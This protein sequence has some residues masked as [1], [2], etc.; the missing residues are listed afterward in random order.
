MKILL[1][2]HQFYPHHYTGTE[3]I[4][5]TTAKYLQKLGH[6]C[7][8]FTYSFHPPS[9]SP[10]WQHIVWWREMYDGLEVINFHWPQAM[11]EFSAIVYHASLKA[12]CDHVIEMVKPDILHVMHPMRSGTICW[13]AQERNIPY[14][15][16]LTDF[17]LICSRGGMLTPAKNLCNGG[18]NGSKCRQICFD[19]PS[20]YYTQRYKEACWLLEHARK[21]MTPSRCLEYLFRQNFAN[22]RSIPVP[23]GI[24]RSFLG[25]NDKKYTS[26]INGKIVYIYCGSLQYIK[27]IQVL[28]AAIQKVR[29]RNIEFRIYGDGPDLPTVQHRA[30]KDPRIK[31]LGV[32]P[33]E[34]VRSVVS[35]A[36]VGIVP[37]VW[38]ENN[39]IIIQEMVS[40]N[41]PV[42]TTDIGS[43]PEKV[44]DGKNGFLFAKGD[45]SGLAAIIDRIAA[46]P[47]LLNEL[48]K[49]PGIADIY[50]IEQSAYLIDAVYHEIVRM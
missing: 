18:D 38:Y 19:I 4:A 26:E 49:N 43:M 28:L 2:V 13:S 11:P 25:F 32:Y 17:W 3:R 14:A 33:P 31:V 21:V 40:M 30:P 9:L 35:E 37:S 46:D 24:E 48:K 42:I 6:Q 27:G 34:R 36:D 39:P 44:V 1:S 8:V 22:W 20:A 23:Y 45:A 7:I 50:S 16:T 47:A 5:Y 10:N 41:L 29:S 15:V 12:F